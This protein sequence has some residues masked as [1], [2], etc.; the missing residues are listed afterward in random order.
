MRNEHT[1]IVLAISVMLN[2][3]S[4]TKPVKAIRNSTFAYST[5]APIRLFV[6]ETARLEPL[7]ELYQQL[8]V[9]TQVPPLSQRLQTTL[10]GSEF[11]QEIK[12]VSGVFVRS[13]RNPFEVTTDSSQAD[14]ELV[15]EIEEIYFTQDEVNKLAQSLRIAFSGVFVQ[16]KTFPEN[17]VKLECRL[18]DKSIDRA[19]YS[20]PVYVRQEKS[21]F[22][23]ASFDWLMDTAFEEVL[24]KFLE[25]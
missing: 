18:Q 21:F 15:I 13:F 22:G 17:F 14:M 7:L 12:G 2:G 1:L 19:V 24:N 10:R 5:V 3:C 4:S 23:K 16:P 9:Q 6:K 8:C 25:K 11:T 20:F